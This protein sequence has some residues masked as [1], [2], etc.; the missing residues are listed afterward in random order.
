MPLNEGE[1]S[2]PLRSAHE[3]LN[4]NQAGRQTAYPFRMPSQEGSRNRLESL[5]E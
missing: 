5:K 2:R 3:R 4:L 1:S